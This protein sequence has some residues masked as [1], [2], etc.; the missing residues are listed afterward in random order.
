MMEKNVGAPKLRPNPL[1]GQLQPLDSGAASEPPSGP[2]Q[3]LRESDGHH[4]ESQSEDESEED[5][6]PD[7]EDPEFFEPQGNLN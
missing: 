1:V 5:S 2:M 4:S 3:H 7:D 6:G